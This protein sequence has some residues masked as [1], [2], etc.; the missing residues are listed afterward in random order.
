[1]SRS[2]A[3]L[4]GQALILAS[5]SVRYVDFDQI[6]GHVGAATSMTLGWGSCC[7]GAGM[8]DTEATVT[9][10]PTLRERRARAGHPLAPRLTICVGL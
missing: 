7:W 10:G 9:P 8:T 2:A 3:R 5:A 6:N 1:M 4:M